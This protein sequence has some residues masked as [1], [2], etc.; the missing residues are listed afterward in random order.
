MV[1]PEPTAT[2]SFLSAA[3]PLDSPPPAAQSVLGLRLPQ[4]Y[5]DLVQGEPILNTVT[6]G[7]PPKA[8]FFRA[9]PGEENATALYSLDAAKMGGDGI[10][11]VSRE[12]AAHIPDQV[13]LVRLRL[14]VTTQGIPYVVPVPLPGPDGKLN[15]W[16]ASLAQA[17]KLAET[18]WVRL[19]ANTARGAYD[20]FRAMGDLGE[21][22]WPEESF[23]AVL[24]VAFHGRVITSTD[25][26]LIRQLMGLIQ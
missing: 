14:V 25:H 22:Q 20:A 7:R 9:R 13:R 6:V 5:P 8:I 11:A 23:D 18:A 26:H 3:S 4:D 1:H 16:H 15:P 10:Y 21:P 2:V 19:S 24:E 12:V 17:M